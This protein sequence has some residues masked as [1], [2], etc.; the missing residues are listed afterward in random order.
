MTPEEW[1]LGKITARRG[2]VVWEMQPGDARELAEY[3]EE[4]T[5]DPKDLAH[6]DVAALRRAADELDPPDGNEPWEGA[7]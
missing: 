7:P 1:T 6:L 3:I 5:P 2:L 4:I